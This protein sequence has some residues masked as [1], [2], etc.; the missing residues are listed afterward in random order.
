MTGSKIHIQVLENMTPC[1]LVITDVSEKRAASV[2]RM[3]E[4]QEDWKPKT[5]AAGIP[6]V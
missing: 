5:E 3:K 1:R 6:R 4:A 2:F